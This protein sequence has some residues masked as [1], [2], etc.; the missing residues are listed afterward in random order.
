[1]TLELA[2][3]RYFI[4]WSRPNFFLGKEL[5][6]N[7][8]HKSKNELYEHEVQLFDPDLDAYVPA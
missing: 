8:I 1:M 7:I 3:D 2:P 6:I 5:R 4:D